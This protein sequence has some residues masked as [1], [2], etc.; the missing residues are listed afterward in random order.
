MSIVWITAALIS[1]S[2]SE[3]SV[4][5]SVS[6]RNSSLLKCFEDADVAEGSALLRFKVSSE[7]AALEIRTE[8]LSPE[9]DGLSQCLQRVL[10]TISFEPA[11]YGADVAYPIRFQ[12]AGGEERPAAEASTQAESYSFGPNPQLFGDDWLVK[13]SKGRP[14]SDLD[15]TLR[16]EDAALHA[17]LESRVTT[18]Y[19]FSAVSG[20]LSVAAFGVAAFGVYQ[21]ANGSDEPLHIGLAAGGAGVSAVFG[22]VTLYQLIRALDASTGAPVW[23]HL[24][25]GQAE[26]L[27]ER[28]N[29][30]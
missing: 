29:A 9:R 30:P 2:P 17:D 27:V 15:L 21:I 16:A 26:G 28:I 8:N 24:D 12:R 19:V 10:A 20:V 11:A 7:G 4:E 13:D 5:S 25:R 23:H 18:R 3:A 14:V 6:R 22:L 1:A